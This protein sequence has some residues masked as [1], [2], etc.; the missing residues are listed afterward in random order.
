[1]VTTI[2]ARRQ[3][4]KALHFPATG[5]AFIMLQEQ[6]IG[7]PLR[8]QEKEFSEVVVELANHAYAD[9]LAGREPIDVWNGA[10]QFFPDLTAEGVS[11]A[12]SMID[13]WV[14]IA[15]CAGKGGANHD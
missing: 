4:I 13:A 7:R 3:L 12:L 9:A 6:A 11:R 2:D 8:R 14:R 10:D 15:Y 5:E 1:M